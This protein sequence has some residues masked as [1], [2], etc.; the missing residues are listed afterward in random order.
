[1]FMPISVT[2]WP[3]V[4]MVFHGC[5]SQ[6]EFLAWQEQTTALLD[7]AEPFVVVTQSLEPIELPEKYRQTEAGWH[8]QNKPK[9]AAHCLAIARVAST[10]AQFERLNLPGMKKLW[11]CEYLATMDLD[12]ALTWAAKHL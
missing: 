11:P 5:I 2:G 7:K 3:V 8:K 10:P 12:E 9:F 4:H 6:S 1:M